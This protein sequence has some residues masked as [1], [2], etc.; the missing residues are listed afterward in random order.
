MDSVESK[1]LFALSA[2]PIWAL[3]ELPNGIDID[4]LRGLDTSEFIEVRLVLMIGGSRSGARHT[5]FQ[6]APQTWYSPSRDR[7]PHGSRFGTW[8]VVFRQNV[9]GARDHPPELRLTD[10]GRAEV[11]R[12][13]RKELDVP[14]VGP[15]AWTDLRQDAREFDRD[16]PSIR[17]TLLHCPLHPR[18]APQPLPEMA[19]VLKRTA[20]LSF[21]ASDTR[22]ITPPM[23]FLW[24][25]AHEACS[26]DA[27]AQWT[28]LCERLWQ[29]ATPLIAR[30]LP[31][32]TNC[33]P[34][35]APR[36]DSKSWHPEGEL[37]VHW[38]SWRLP[39]G[40]PPAEC[41][42]GVVEV[43][44]GRERVVPASPLHPPFAKGYPHGPDGVELNPGMRLLGWWHS[45]LNPAGR[46]LVAAVDGLMRA[47]EPDRIP[48]TRASEDQESDIAKSF[49]N[50]LWISRATKGG[51][52]SEVLRK[53]RGRGR[54]T[55]TIRRGTQY[56]YFVP[57]IAN[58]Y[59]QYGEKLL[60]ALKENRNY[61]K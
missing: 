9:R 32:S 38:L 26:G 55:R 59:V 15:P 2:R 23:T 25:P 14:G 41:V 43:V 28:A 34:L 12:L 49:R 36:L 3:D 37:L 11:A 31:E 18:H 40:C 61:P 47:L 39:E 50:A 7:G 33:D 30:V 13:R 24:S 5:V 6:P 58:E 4:V 51:L 29:L 1:A 21:R 56:L 35:H 53:C 57:E 17:S 46:A 22:R 60:Q 45:T 8:D 52:N 20:R 19:R 44:G 48:G 10:L 16:N 27:S 42:L 54:L